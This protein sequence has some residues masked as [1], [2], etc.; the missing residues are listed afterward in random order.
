[1]I[2]YC[3]QF[4]SSVSS[5]SVILILITSYLDA[6]WDKGT[7][8]FNK[9]H[10]EHHDEFIVRRCSLVKIEHNE[11]QRTANIYQIE[12]KKCFAEDA[13]NKSSFKAEFEAPDSVTITYPTTGVD[14]TDNS[15]EYEK[16]FKEKSEKAKEKHKQD[17][18]KAK[19]SIAKLFNEDLHNQ[20]EQERIQYKREKLRHQTKV[21][22]KMPEK[23]DN[24]VISIGG[25]TITQSTTFYETEN[26]SFMAKLIWLIAVK[27]SLQDYKE[28]SDEEESDDEFSSVLERMRNIRVSKNKNGGMDST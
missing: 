1:V 3:V 8:D 20:R 10:P 23:L 19:P 2:I 28:Y 26:G 11:R 25:K 12:T 22:I 7:I 9:T 13:A 5:Y 18:T 4:S 16:A 24:S 14:Y 6:P 27:G 15:A 17:P 21:T